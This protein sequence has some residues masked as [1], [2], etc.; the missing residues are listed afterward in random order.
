MMTRMSQKM[1]ST[2]NDPPSAELTLGIYNKVRKGYE[3]KEIYKYESVSSKVISE[4]SSWFD[5][6][7]GL[8]D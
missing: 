6:Y 1:I 5:A 7:T 4:S 8:G 3:K 2:K